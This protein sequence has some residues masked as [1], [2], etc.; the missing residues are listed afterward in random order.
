MSEK[1]THIW[2]MDLNRRVYPRDANGRATGCSIYREHWVKEEVLG[3]TSRSW[4]IGYKHN[5]TK[6]PKSGP[7][8]YGYRW[9][10]AEVDDACWMHDN[11]HAIARAVQDCRDVAKVR[12]VAEILG[13]EGVTP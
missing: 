6:I 11:Q 3:E 8:P 10:E 9:T 5:P 13:L 7:L 2:R 1:P 12:A 4:L